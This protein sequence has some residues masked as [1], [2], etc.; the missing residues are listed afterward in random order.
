LCFSLFFFPSLSLIHSLLLHF[1]SKEKDKEWNDA[2]PF[3]LNNNNL[4]QPTSLLLLR[5]THTIVHPHRQH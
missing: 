4:Q 5:P 3:Q 1:F 2:A